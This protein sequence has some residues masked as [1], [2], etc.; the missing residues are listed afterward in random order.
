MMKKIFALMLVLSLAFCMIV[1]CGGSGEGGGESGGSEGGSEGG[2]GN[3]GGSGSEGGSEGGSEVT[4]YEYMVQVTD[5]N[6]APVANASVVIMKDG[7]FVTTV[8]TGAD[9]YA[10]AELEDGTYT[11]TLMGSSAFTATVN[12]ASFTDRVASFSVVTKEAEKTVTY[13]V[14]VVDQ[15]GDAVVGVKLQA[16]LEACRSM[17]DTDAEG[18]SVGELPEITEGAYRAQ[19]TS[20]PD[21]YSVD[22]MKMYYDF[23]E[24][25]TVTITVTKD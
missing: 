15:N 14:I 19:L 11:A 7:N 8:K 24:N 25:N 12:Q 20:L 2:S 13:T 3:E 17:P 6:S 16:C 18:K 4:K 21:G 22:D 1:S 9:G 23:D 5:Q 10:K